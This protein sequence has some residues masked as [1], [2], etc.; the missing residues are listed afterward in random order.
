MLPLGQLL[1]LMAGARAGVD[2]GEAGPMFD[3]DF[4]PFVP[5]GRDALLDSLMVSGGQITHLQGTFSPGSD[6]SDITL[7]PADA[8][9][10]IP[11]PN[12]IRGWAS[13]SKRFCRWVGWGL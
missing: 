10:K 2:S 8:P 11:E 6:W 7:M 1:D 12:S 13:L 5:A 4:L 9:Q 3:P